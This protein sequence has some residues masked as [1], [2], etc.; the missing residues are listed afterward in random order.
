MTLDELWQ[1][2]PIVL[3]PNNPCWK[4]W[5]DDEIDKLKRLLS[6]CSPVIH[7]IGS[8]A[9]PDIKA[10]PIVDILVEITHNENLSCLRNTMENA[11][12]IC[13]SSSSN[14]LSFNKGYTPAG[15]A[16][17]VFHIHI[18]LKGDNDEIIFR[19]Y[20][21]KNP[22]VAHEY[23]LLK[24]SLLPEY[25][26]DRDKYTE[27]KTEFVRRVTALAKDVSNE[28]FAIIGISQKFCN[29][30][31]IC[32]AAIFFLCVPL[33]AVNIVTYSVSDSI[34][35]SSS[36]ELRMLFKWLS[37][38][39]NRV[40]M[41]FELQSTNAPFTIY[42]AEWQHCDSMYEPMEP[43]YLIA[44]T[45][46][47][48][49]KNT[50]WHITLDFPFSSIFDEYDTLILYTDRGIIRCP[51]SREGQ[52]RETIE[53]LTND[54]EMQIDTPK[55]SSRMAWNILVMVLTGVIAAGGAV[56][57][58]VHRRFVQKHREIEEL[59]LL[60]AERTDRNLELEA[61]V[62]ALYGSRLDTLNMLCNEYFEKSESDKLKLTLYNEVEKHILALRDTKSIAELEGIVNTF[63]DNILIRIREQLPELNKNDRIFLTYLYAGFSPRAV[64]IFT[65]IK[66]KN[67]YNRRSRLKDRI[68]ASD[69]QDKEYFVSKM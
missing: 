39:D 10:K 28:N 51:T 50:K 1:L 69:A 22:N 14:R 26:R 36:E 8:T 23:E 34:P 45:N 3:V 11:G 43:F 37:N 2:F 31:L 47:S 44:Q 24:M 19:D 46:E 59:S 38:A 17:R 20:L 33:N 27:A 18:H 62:D 41:S 65:N 16:E 4:E 6:D 12:Y 13:M 52:L 48:T 63:L 35:T 54:Y 57:V 66:I 64:C 67:F 56:F 55:K 29:R 21:R 40:R 25:S 30:L 49:G 42:K 5:A 68:L 61:K 9:I 53:I 15:Y 32:L 7:H 58:I 60:I